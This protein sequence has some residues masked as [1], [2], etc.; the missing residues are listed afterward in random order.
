MGDPETSDAELL[1]LARRDPEAFATL[2]DRHAAAIFGWFLA[3]VEN[4]QAALD[5]TA[6]AFAQVWVGRKRFQAPADNSAG[7]WIQGI[8]KNLYRQSVRRQSLALKASRRLRLEAP[9]VSHADDVDDR[10]DA[11]SLGPDAMRLLDQL[12][13]E[14]REAVRLRIV[15]ELPYEAI[16]ER[17]QSSTELA[18]TRVRRGLSAI[19]AGLTEQGVPS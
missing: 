11:A 12:P 15:D 4:R 17:M 6:E 14:Q 16:A 19:R 10:V 18:R 13:A 5:L 8:A 2:Y 9:T 3:R 7:P 1:Q